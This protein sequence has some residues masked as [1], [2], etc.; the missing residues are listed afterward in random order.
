MKNT[1]NKLS[2]SSVKLTVKC[3][4]MNCR[5]MKNKALASDNYAIKDIVSEE[6][7]INMKCLLPCNIAT[8]FKSNKHVNYKRHANKVIRNNHVK[9]SP[10]LTQSKTNE[11]LMAISANVNGLRGKIDK[12]RLI[13]CDAKPH[14]IACQETK[15][16]EKLTIKLSL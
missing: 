13:A 1:S 7:E 2:N 4:V 3:A 5:S 14:I 8:S 9:T 6:N 12:I 10:N 11:A 16:G 15:L